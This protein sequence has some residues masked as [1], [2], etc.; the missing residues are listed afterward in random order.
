MSRRLVALAALVFLAAMPVYASFANVER[1]LEAR[2]GEPTWIPMLGLV[3]VATWVVHPKGVHDIQLAVFE[4]KHAHLDG[5]EIERIVER[6]VPPGF[7]PMVRTRNSRS[8]EWTFIY[9]KPHGE[10][11][12]E[13][14]LVS[15]DKDDTVVMQLDVEPE[16]VM[17][18]INHPA[19]IAKIG[20]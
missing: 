4:E 9:A 12:M 2:L 11:R 5:A 3:R 1:A 18:D 6:E 19:R 20:R 15:H 16:E 10:N 14:F 13:L 17:R 7:H 8:G